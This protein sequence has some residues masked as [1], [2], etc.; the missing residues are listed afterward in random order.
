MAAPAFQNIGPLVDLCRS[1]L[2]RVLEQVIEL[3]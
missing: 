3:L 1:F 2:I